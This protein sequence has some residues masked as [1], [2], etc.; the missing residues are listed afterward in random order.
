MYSKDSS[1]ENGTKIKGKGIAKQA[2]QKEKENGACNYR[3]NEQ[4]Y[5]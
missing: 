4:G 2:M 1:E 5:S 3:K